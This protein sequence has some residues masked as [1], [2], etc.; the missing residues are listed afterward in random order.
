VLS[1]V[2]AS[3]E[4]KLGGGTD[5]NNTLKA[6]STLVFLKIITCKSNPMAV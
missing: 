2:K 6:N 5:F 3:R 1:L 4:V